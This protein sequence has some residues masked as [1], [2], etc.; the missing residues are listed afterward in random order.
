L[1]TVI[2]TGALGFIGGHTC[3]A[4][5]KAGYHVIGIDNNLTI[6]ESAQY[7][8][9]FV[10]SDFV[11]V[12]ANIAHSSNAEAI[13]HI[14]A[15]S[16]VGPS[17]TNPGLYYD[18]N[19]SKT[20]LLLDQLKELNWNGTFVFSSSAAVYGNGCLC[21]I[22]EESR[23]SPV[24]PYGNSKLICE[25][26]IRDHCV[27]NTNIKG[28][29]LRYF[30]AAGCDNDCELGNIKDDTHLVPK[31]ITALLNNELLIINGNSFDTEDKTCIRDYLHV[32]DIAN[33]HVKAVEYSHIVE[34]FGN[35][36]LGTGL[37]FSNL[38]IIMMAEKVTNLKL[39]FK[40]G[41]MREGD[42]D[43]LI[44]NPN[45]FM[46]LTNWHPEHSSIENIIET[47]YNWMKKYYI[48]DNNV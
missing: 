35:F 6:P 28:I 16:L 36:N 23:C 46:K 20:N 24:S 26:I 2:I 48:S 29:A 12:C 42:P 38:E 43:E 45:K 10:K 33:A 11:E 4:F 13:I 34:S 1:K 44:A 5:K 19:A 39:N 9:E 14:A 27:A 41:P 32:T 40:Y 7:I 25:Q 18:N 17:I 37:G 30:N 3:K 22:L 47:T 21:P 8:D 31:V 15:T